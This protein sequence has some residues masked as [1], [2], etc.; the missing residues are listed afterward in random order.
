MPSANNWRD[1]IWVQ[2]LSRSGRS[3]SVKLRSVELPMKENNQMAFQTRCL[4]AAAAV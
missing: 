3:R 1:S 4:C 2:T